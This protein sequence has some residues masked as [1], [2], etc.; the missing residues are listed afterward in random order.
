M[1]RVNLIPDDLILTWQD[2]LLAF[3]DRRFV[4]VLVWT[5]AVVG[6]CVSGLALREGLQVHRDTKRT[7][8][9]Q[10]QQAKLKAELDNSKA[11]LT[12]LDQTKAELDVQLKRLMQQISFLSA[13]RER[14][15]ELATILH[16]LK[17]TI[18]YG[19]WLT[20]LDVNVEGQ[21]RVSG[22]AFED[23]LVTQFMSSLKDNPRFTNVAFSFTRKAK[24]GKTGIVAFEITC[25]AVPL[26]IGAEA[27][28]S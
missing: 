4:T 25:H 19:I 23:R 9:L 27:P 21:V 28:S 12:Q 20:E 13:Y 8:T 16:E 11:Y 18:P 24:I 17:Q 14:Q 7:A 1:D 2:R 15:G 22:G 6:V 26:A 10:T 3:V 5:V